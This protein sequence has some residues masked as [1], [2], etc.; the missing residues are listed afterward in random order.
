[1]RLYKQFSMVFVFVRAFLWDV[2]ESFAKNRQDAISSRPA[3]RELEIKSTILLL[4]D[5]EMY[6]VSCDINARDQFLKTP[7]ADTENLPVCQQY[8]KYEA[9]DIKARYVRFIRLLLFPNHSFD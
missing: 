4:G 8:V 9:K 1:M 5:S 7:A 3:M 6:G 2:S